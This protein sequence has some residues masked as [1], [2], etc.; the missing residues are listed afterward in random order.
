MNESTKEYSASETGSRYD[1][2]NKT[3][4]LNKG[5]LKIPKIRCSCTDKTQLQLISHF[6]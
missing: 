2:E 5:Y 4:L 6:K 3:K 1:S